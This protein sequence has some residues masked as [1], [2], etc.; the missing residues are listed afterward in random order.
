LLGLRGEWEAFQTGK[1]IYLQAQSLVQDS[2]S[3]IEDFGP[4]D[5]VQFMVSTTDK[6]IKGVNRG[7]GWRTRQVGGHIDPASFQQ[8]MRSM[9]AMDSP[10]QR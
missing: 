1:D 2:V 10:T 7:T 5:A 6:T 8:P 3:P 4:G 9:E